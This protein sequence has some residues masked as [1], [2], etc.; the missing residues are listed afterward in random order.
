MPKCPIKPKLSMTEQARGKIAIAP[1]KKRLKKKVVIP[2]I[3]INDITIL[4]KDD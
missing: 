4:N 3:R 1:H 2:N